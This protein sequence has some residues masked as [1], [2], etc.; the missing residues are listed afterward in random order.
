MPALAPLPD[1]AEVAELEEELQAATAAV[2]ELRSTLRGRLEDQLASKL[3]GQRPQIEDEDEA[4]DRGRENWGGNE[5]AALF[6]ALPEG[7]HEQLQ[8][9]LDRENANIPAL[10]ARLNG[11]ADRL[12]RVVHAVSARL[13]RPPPNTI[14]RV[15]TAP[16]TCVAAVPATP[17]T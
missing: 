8:G 2:Q 9:R 17:E 14:E 4:S 13:D 12:Q 7:G 15:V 11:A 1:D 6:Q 3:A 5:A 10:R 16:E